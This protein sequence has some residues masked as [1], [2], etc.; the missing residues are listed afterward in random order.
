M[1]PISPCGRCDLSRMRAWGWGKRMSPYLKP[2]LE[3]RAWEWNPITLIDSLSRTAELPIFLDRLFY[4][5]VL[6]FNTSHWFFFS[7]N[8]KYKTVRVFQVCSTSSTVC[9]SL[10]YILTYSGSSSYGN[11]SIVPLRVFVSITQTAFPW[12]I[13]LGI[14]ISIN[15][16]R[17]GLFIFPALWAM[18]CA[19]GTASCIF[20]PCSTKRYPTCLVM[21]WNTIKLTK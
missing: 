1:Q 13:W 8:V 21:C 14:Q 3:R 9:K 5:L 4:M 18:A 19:A 17:T 2:P 7:W 12:S 6:W 11:M 16:A 10:F 15:L 20:P